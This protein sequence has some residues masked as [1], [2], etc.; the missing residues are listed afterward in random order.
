MC[1]FKEKYGRSFN[2]AMVFMKSHYGAYSDEEWDAVSRETGQFKSALEVA[3]AVAVMNE[4]ERVFSVM[5]KGAFR[6][7]DNQKTHDVETI[8]RVIFERTYKFARK[9]YRADLSKAASLQDVRRNLRT[10]RHI[11]PLRLKLRKPVTKYLLKIASADLNLTMLQRNK[12]NKRR[13]NILVVYFFG[14]DHGS[15]SDKITVL[16]LTCFLSI[17]CLALRF[18][19][20]SK[21][22]EKS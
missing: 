19:T 20:L 8:Y 1:D 12:K 14:K 16:P 21:I 11:R 17:K 13:G 2:M 10:F 4:I 15:Y 18:S 7:S 6:M 22:I 5:E 9:C 3:L